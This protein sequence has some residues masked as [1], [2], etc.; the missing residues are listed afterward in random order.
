MV[1]KT[2]T[3]TLHVKEAQLFS[4]LQIQNDL[5]QILLKC[6]KKEELMPVVV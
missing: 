3:L 4:R 5:I 1:Q 6:L 2:V